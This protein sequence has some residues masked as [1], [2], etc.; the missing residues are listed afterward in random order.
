MSNLRVRTRLL[1]YYGLLQANY[2]KKLIETMRKKVMTEKSSE[3][4]KQQ[5][6]E[7]HPEQRNK[8]E[9]IMLQD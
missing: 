8:E 6:Q 5:W 7:I 2:Y 9:K 3:N 4:K 1:Y